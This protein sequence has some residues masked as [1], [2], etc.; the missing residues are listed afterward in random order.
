[1]GP[2]DEPEGDDE[3]NS[4]GAPTASQERKNKNPAGS[5]RRGFPSQRRSAFDY[6]MILATTPAP[7]V[8]PPSRIAK[9]SF[10]SMAIG[11]ISSTLSS[12]LSPGMII[13]TP[14]FSLM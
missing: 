4:A 6:S 2:R 3:L 14:S 11:V 8:R 5:L 1:M 7:T 12:A 13:S 9:R 10:S